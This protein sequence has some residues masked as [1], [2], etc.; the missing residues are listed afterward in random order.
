MEMVAAAKMRRSVEATLNTRMYARLARE[1][2]GHLSLME[3]R[4]SGL[5]AC[6]PVKKLL[7]VLVSSNRGLCGSFNSNLFKKTATVLRDTDIGR[8]R[9][10]NGD[11][12]ILP[13]GPI[14][15][16]VVGVGRRSASFAKKNGYNLVAAFDALPERLQY[17]DILPIT[18]LII[19]SFREKTYDKVVVA[20]TE[21]ES[22]IVQTPK[23]RQLLPISAI[24][25]DK[26]LAKFDTENKKRI[27]HPLPED[28]LVEI[29]NYTFEPS[30]EDIA[31]VVLPR[32]VEVQLYQA[33]LESAASE[34]SAR[35]VAMKNASDAAS[36][37]I[38]GLTLQYNKGR[39]AA[40]TQEI[41][42]I[43]GGASAL[44]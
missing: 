34:H 27:D 44:E 29:E 33:I 5:L 25:I 26:M 11:A 15:I 32:L 40:I 3:E 10:V 38:S 35:M 4:E 8:H 12:D 22:S 37:M 41:S 20:F 7:V 18:N 13:E 43:V 31:E 36:D 1:L 42:E 16:D 19:S 6:R 17:E 2:M 9:R 24:D 21:Y 14:E 28:E 30:V 23:L 39:Q